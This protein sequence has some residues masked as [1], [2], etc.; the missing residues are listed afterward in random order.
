[1]GDRGQSSHWKGWQYNQEGGRESHRDNQEKIRDG[2][3]CN[4]Y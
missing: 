4:N 2:A 3:V 1:M